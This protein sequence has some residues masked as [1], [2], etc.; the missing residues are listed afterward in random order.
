MGEP[1]IGEKWDDGKPD[2]SLLLAFP[3]AL[4]EVA[5]VGTFGTQVKGYA[6]GS[7]R[8]VENGVTRYTAALL[9]HL[10]KEEG[11]DYDEESHLLHTA[12]TAWNALARLELEL[13]RRRATGEPTNETEKT[14]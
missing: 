8:H 9:R 4:M 7:W 2:T 14:A 12:H 13:M 3:L 5:R 1:V 11:A 10:L 6:R